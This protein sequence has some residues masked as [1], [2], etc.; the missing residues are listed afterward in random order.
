MKTKLK[1]LLL[2][3]IVAAGL[4]ASANAALIS[5][6]YSLDASRFV[7]QFEFS[8]P[9]PVDP[10][11]LDFRL[12]FDNSADIEATTV[13]LTLLSFNLPYGV[14]YSYISAID[15]LTIGT[16]LAGPASCFNS[17]DSFCNFIR[18]ATSLAP[19]TIGFSQVTSSQHIWNAEVY[20]LDFEDVGRGGAVP[21]PATW[22]LMI[23]GFGAAGARLRR[24][25][26]RG[27]IA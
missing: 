23:L 7:P 19:Y 14:E 17:K 26:L 6:E 12:D 15:H 18:E 27:S 2:A 25:A 21:E 13:G 22:A 4:P 24:R 9:N 1:G 5:R 20:S 16:N 11:S 10:V 8:L 3:A